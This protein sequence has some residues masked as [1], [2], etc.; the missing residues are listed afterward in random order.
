[1]ESRGLWFAFGIGVKGRG[2]DPSARSGIDIAGL[3][4]PGDPG[5]NTNTVGLSCKHILSQFAADAIPSVRRIVG[6]DCHKLRMACTAFVLN[7]VSLFG[8]A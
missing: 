5:P 8:I 6:D 7:L 2:N 4:W 1:M 3:T